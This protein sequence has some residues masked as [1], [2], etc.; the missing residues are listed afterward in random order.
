MIEG[1]ADVLLLYK[2]D[3]YRKL[4]TI[5]C[6]WRLPEPVCVSENNIAFLGVRHAAEKRLGCYTVLA[7]GLTRRSRQSCH[8]TSCS[9]TQR[10]T[11]A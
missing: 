3:N 5:E 1:R 8:C 9:L 2:P 7:I 10:M 4:C 6:A 11:W